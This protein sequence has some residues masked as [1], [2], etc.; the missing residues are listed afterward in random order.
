VK[1]NDAW[2]PQTVDV[3]HEISAEKLTKKF[4]HLVL[5]AV[6]TAEQQMHVYSSHRRE[7]DAVSRICSNC[8]LNLSGLVGSFPSPIKV[9]SAPTTQEIRLDAREGSDVKSFYSTLCAPY[10]ACSGLRIE[11]PPRAVKRTQ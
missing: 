3:W 4:D 9:P 2:L 10:L 1:P 8:R 6:R 7:T 11:T 5:R